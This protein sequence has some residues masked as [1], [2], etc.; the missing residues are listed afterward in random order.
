MG[1]LHSTKPLTPEMESDHLGLYG[2]SYN[3][4]LERA[5]DV[6]RDYEKFDVLLKE[7]LSVS[8]MRRSMARDIFVQLFSFAIPAPA[9]I[10]LLYDAWVKHQAKYPTA[11]LVDLGCGT[12]LF[13]WLLRR[14]GVAEER[15]IGLDLPLDQARPFQR[16]YWDAVIRDDSYVI[17]PEDFVLVAWGDNSTQRWGDNSTQRWGDNCEDEADSYLTSGGKCLAILGEKEGDATYPWD[18]FLHDATIEVE[19]YPVEPSAYA[20]SSDGLSF[21]R[22]R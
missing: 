8:P 3:D 12:G 9:T 21:N 14:A 15:L 22:P 10:D 20:I 2:F 6:G 17:K 13:L 4:F 18:R 5:L 1:G 19:Y 11:N 16:T 7:F